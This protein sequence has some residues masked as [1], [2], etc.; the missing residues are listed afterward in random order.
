MVCN[1]EY[2]LTIQSIRERKHQ[3]LALVLAKGAT[4]ILL[5]YTVFLVCEDKRL[6]SIPPPPFLILVA[7]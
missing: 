6:Y 7:T 1:L 4:E 3:I 5:T 2:E